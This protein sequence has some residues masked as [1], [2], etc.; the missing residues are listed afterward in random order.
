MTAYNVDLVDF[1]STDFNRPNVPDRL[2]A[3]PVAVVGDAMDRLGLCNASLKVSWTGARCVGPAFP[4][5]VTEGD[6]AAIHAALSFLRRGDVVVVNGGG[7]VNRALIGDRL[8]MTFIDRGIAGAVIDGCIR[9]TA[10]IEEL[11]FPVWSR[12]AN[13]AGPFKNGPGK[14]GAP[15][16]IGGVVVEPGD[17]IT[18]DA[19]GVAVIPRL[20]LE[21]VLSRAEEILRV[22]QASKEELGESKLKEERKDKI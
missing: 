14:V 6:N 15:V 12:G 18:A 21:A 10:D 22:E 9:D 2:T 16:A 11:R 17:I 7:S 3:I 8:A 20:S 13:P 5:W 4:I 19:D 1:M